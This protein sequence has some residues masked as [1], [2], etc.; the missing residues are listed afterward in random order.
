MSR[1]EAPTAGPKNHIRVRAV[2]V[3]PR[4]STILFLRHSHQDPEREYWVLP[5]GGV[6]PGE[7]A[8]DAVLRE[9]REEAG[10]RAHVEKLLYVTDRPNGVPGPEIAFYFLCRTTE[11]PT[12]GAELL[13]REGYKDEFV[14]ANP[15]EVAKL[16]LFP[17]FLRRI[18][19]TDAAE[20]FPNPPVYLVEPD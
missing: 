11:E 12:P 9:L 17:P 15:A 4:R 18:L 8:V 13:T 3:V 19:P 7:S 1:A 2:A 10:L 20:G 6:N 14:F 5:G 16:R